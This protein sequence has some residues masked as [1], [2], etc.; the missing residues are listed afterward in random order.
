MPMFLQPH[1]G[2]GRP[3]RGARGRRRKCFLRFMGRAAQGQPGGLLPARPVR[4]RTA[5]RV[6]ASAHSA[7]VTRALSTRNPGRGLKNRS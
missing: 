2:M 7:W 6:A 5:V 1:G 3:G 4:M